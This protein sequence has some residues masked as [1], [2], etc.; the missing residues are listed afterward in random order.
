[1]VIGASLPS[2]AAANMAGSLAVQVTCL[3]GGFLLSRSQMPMLV[4]ALAGLSYVRSGKGQISGGH[5]GGTQGG[6]PGRSTRHCPCP[7]LLSSM[8]LASASTLPHIT[9]YSFEALLI[10][11]FHGADGFRFTAFHNPGVPP[12]RIQH[13][14]VT[15]DQILQVCWE[16]RSCRL[17]VDSLEATDVLYILRCLQTFGFSLDAHQSD[18]LYLIGLVLLFLMTTFLLLRFNRRS[19]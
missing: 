15:G 14:D 6:H 19:N 16:T 17:C 11:E 3:L 13:V 4:Q 8:P 10:T 1:M 2:V 9:R 12:D 18:S 7:C 5:S